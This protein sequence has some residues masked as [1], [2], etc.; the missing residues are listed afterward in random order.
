MSAEKKGKSTVGKVISY[1][2]VI[3]LVIGL[4][5]FFALFT[6][7]F[8]DDFKTFY[9][10]YDGE[11]IISNKSE[12]VFETDK[13]LRFDCKYTFVDMSKDEPLGFN[14]KVIPN[15]T[16]ETNFD[17]TVDNQMYAYI[18]EKDLTAAFDIQLYDRYFTLNIPKS[19]SMQTVLGKIYDGKNV[20][21]VDELNSDQY[22]YTLCISS[23]NEKVSYMI[24]FKFSVGVT[25]IELDK[26]SIIL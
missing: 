2:L 12:Y 16:D 14:V 22:Y 5:G 20:E 15:I 3:L 26:D 25:G 4:I 8:T 13:G 23:Y 18:G 11:W 24:N 10:E 17:F 21:I 19:T 6:N 9:I 7:N 1:I